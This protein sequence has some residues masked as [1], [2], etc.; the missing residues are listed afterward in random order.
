MKV[1]KSKLFL[2]VSKCCQCLIRPWWRKYSQI[3]VRVL[4]L[5]VPLIAVNRPV[6]DQYKSIFNQHHKYFSVDFLQKL[7][8]ILC[9]VLW[10]CP[11]CPIAL[12]IMICMNLY[13]SVL[14]F[15]ISYFL[16]QTW[17]S[18]KCVK[19]K[20]AEC[21]VCVDQ[22]QTQYYSSPSMPERERGAGPIWWLVIIFATIL[23]PI[24]RRRDLA[25]NI[26]CQENWTPLYQKQEG[27]F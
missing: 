25:K 19:L 11:V 10:I 23:F 4:S 20:E 18:R 3:N 5:F 8:L 17:S 12:C 22:M 13:R 1:L 21:I 14:A 16:V 6:G 7:Q 15:F 24:L 9:V 27:L 2:F 26:V